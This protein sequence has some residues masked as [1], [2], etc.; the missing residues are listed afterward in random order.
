VSS[1]Q[2][3][4]GKTPGASPAGTPA[5]TP[6]GASPAGTPDDPTATAA[7]QV[8]YLQSHG[9]RCLGNPLWQDSLWLDPTQPLVAHYTEE[10]CLYQVEVPEEYVDETT[11]KVAVRYKT[12]QRQILAQDG[13]GGAPV[14]ARRSVYHPKGVPLRMPAALETQLERDA[15]EVLRREEERRKERK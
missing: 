11:R 9:W 1:E 15:R 8:A 14:A 10:P 2:A 6:L 13:R 3:R 4:P 7:S 12:E 5:V